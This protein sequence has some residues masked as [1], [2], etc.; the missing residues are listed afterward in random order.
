MVNSRSATY[1]LRDIR[2]FI[3]SLHISVWGF[4][5]DLDSKEYI[6]NAGEPWFDSWVGK[7]PWRRGRLPTSV[8]LGFPGDSGS[9]E[10]ACN[11][12]DL[13][14]I[15]G[16]GRSP[17]GGHGKSLKYSCLEN[18]HGQRSLAGCSPWDHKES[19]M[20]EWLSTSQLSFCFILS[21]I[22]S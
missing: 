8:F 1:L 22:F 21:F 12:G 14:L 10:S 13:G 16:L 20:T 18:A 15:L 7:I 3:L 17:G 5:G 2:K 19:D 9:K 6:C 11:A 4:P